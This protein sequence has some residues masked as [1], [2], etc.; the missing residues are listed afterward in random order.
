VN[1]VGNRIQ[2][3]RTQLGLSRSDIVESISTITEEELEKLEEN[4]DKISNPSLVQLRQMAFVLKTTAADLVEPNMGGRVIS[5]LNN[6]LEGRQAARGYS[7]ISDE[8]R[9][10]IMRRVLLRVVDS[11]EK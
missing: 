2:E 11:L 4:T 9:R 7:S 3:L 5:F 8:D 6:W 1:I 10:K